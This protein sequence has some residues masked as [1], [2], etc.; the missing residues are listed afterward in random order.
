MKRQEE[1]YQIVW[2]LCSAFPKAQTKL[3]TNEKCLKTNKRLSIQKRDKSPVFKL[4]AAH[5]LFEI[6]STRKGKG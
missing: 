3:S 5:A 2:I 6:S 1:E 4:T